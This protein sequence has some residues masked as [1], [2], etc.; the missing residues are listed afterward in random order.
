MVIEA[1]ILCGERSAAMA[2]KV[3]QVLMPHNATAS[4]DFPLPQFVDD[5]EETFDS[6]VDLIARLEQDGKIPYSL[7]WNNNDDEEPFSCMLHFTR[8][9][10]LIAGIAVRDENAEEWMKRLA[11]VTGGKYG[12]ITAEEPPPDTIKSFIDLCRS[13]HVT[14]LIDGKLI[15]AP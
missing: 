3:V 7:Y 2:T 5:P 6:V 15:A 11:S 9:C 1:Y 12:Y 14:R 13:S 4:A 10:G 8:D